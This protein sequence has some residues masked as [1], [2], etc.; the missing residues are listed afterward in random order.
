MGLSFRPRVH[1]REL[2]GLE[3]IS[4]DLTPPPS[5]EQ[6]QGLLLHWVR[7]ARGLQ[8]RRGEWWRLRASLVLRE[9]FLL[10][11]NT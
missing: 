8:S 3:P 9:S 4:T 5:N 11:M 2:V 6:I 10:C 7:G 1:T